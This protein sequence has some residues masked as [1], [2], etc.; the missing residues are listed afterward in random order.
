VRDEVVV[1]RAGPDHAGPADDQ[2]HAEAAFPSRAFFAVEGGDPA[3]GPAARFRPVVSAV[4]HDRVVVDPEF[5]QLVQEQAD[6]IV[7]FHHAIGIEPD[8]GPALRFLLQPRPDVHARR[9]HPDEER[10]V[11]FVGAVNEI[12]ARGREFFIRRLHPLAGQRPGILDAAVGIGVDHAARS[13]LLAELRVLRVIVGFRLFLGVQVIEVAEELVKAVG[14]RQMLVAVAQVVLA[15]L[16]GGVALLL[17]QVGDRGRPIGSAVV[18]A[19]HA[20]GQQAGP[21]G[22]LAQDERGPPG[23]AALLGVRVGEHRAL[24]G[25][26]IDVGRAI[27]H[28]PMVVGTDVVDADIVAPDDED[29]RLL[30]LGR[31]GAGGQQAHDGQD[32]HRQRA[33]TLS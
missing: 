5:L 8:P 24:A 12:Q 22:M 25:D 33:K 14:R 19:G 6:V 29:V 2:G 1:D 17:Q 7:V 4:D 3:V 21:E 28:D 15:E 30:L 32:G 31:G 20:D 18:A 9:A 16:P 26:P 11:R 23:G 13:E 27:P 10:L